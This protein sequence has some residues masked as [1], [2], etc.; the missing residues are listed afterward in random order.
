[1]KFEKIDSG[2]RIVAVVSSENKVITDVNPAL[3]LLMS[4][5]YGA[6]TKYIV[7]YKKL[8]IEDFFVLEEIED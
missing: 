8:V 5:K 1:M 4:A 6:G 2:N 3:D 7:V